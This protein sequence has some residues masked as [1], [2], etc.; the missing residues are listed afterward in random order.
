[1]PARR[2]SAARDLSAELALAQQALTE[3]AAA[4][5][6]QIEIPTALVPAVTLLVELAAVDP[7]VTAPRKALAAACRE[8]AAALA[9]AH[10]GRSIEVRVPPFAAVQCGR[11]DGGQVH[12]RDTPP[13]VVE[14]DPATFLLLTTGRLSWAEGRASHRISAS[15]NRSDLADW[16]DR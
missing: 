15:G 3:H 11:P 1:M 7:G 9:A 6:E 10:P 13:N 5:G 12:T 14:M 16:F 4:T 2:T 8:Q